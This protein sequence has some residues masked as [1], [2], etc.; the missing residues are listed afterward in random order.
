MPSARSIRSRA[1][2]SAERSGRSG[3][4]NV[5]SRPSPAR[6]RRRGGHQ[7]RERGA[8]C[9]QEVDPQAHLTPSDAVDGAHGRGAIHSSNGSRTRR[10][11]PRQSTMRTRQKMSS[12]R[13]HPPCSPFPTYSTAAWRPTTSPSLRATL[14]RRRRRQRGTHSLPPSKCTRVN[15]TEPISVNILRLYSSL[16]YNRS[17]LGNAVVARAAQC[18]RRRAPR[19][20]SGSPMC[21]RLSSWYRRGVCGADRGRWGAAAPPLAP[22]VGRVWRPG[23]A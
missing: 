2:S 4:A 3:T 8:E 21:S 14:R 11:A 20:S 10:A 5:S 9:G 15:G 6:P 12:P 19:R 18:N 22:P 7:P 1:P 16:P 13:P 17:L 23:Q